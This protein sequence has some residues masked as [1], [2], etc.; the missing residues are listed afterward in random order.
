MKRLVMKAQRLDAGAFL[1][2]RAHPDD[3]G[4]DLYASATV[5]VWPASFVDVHC[6]V[7]VEMPK[8]AW[9]LL[10]G[11]SSTLRKRGLLVNPGIIDPGYRGEL[12]AGVWNLGREPVEVN[13]GERLA[14]LIL[15]SNLTEGVDVE[16]ASTLTEHPRGLRGFG[17]SGA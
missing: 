8:G 6:G 9:G 10:Q 13:I 15:L 2:T 17:S 11:R 7:A 12:F 14:Q 4:F 1:P 16:W 5:T 3:A